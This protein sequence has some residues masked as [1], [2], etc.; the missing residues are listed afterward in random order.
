MISDL[1]TKILVAT[2]GSAGSVTAAQRAAEMAHVF[3][4]ELHVVHVVPVSQPHHLIGADA[5]GS[6]LYEEDLQ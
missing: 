6:S 4:S 1:P 2:D 3:G 5:E